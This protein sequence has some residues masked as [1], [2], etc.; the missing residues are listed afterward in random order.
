MH[1]ENIV[2]KTLGIKDHRIVK[3][4]S[5]TENIVVYLEA[6]RK[7][8]LPCGNCGARSR[9]A[10]RVRTERMFL[11]VPLWGI[12]MFLHYRPWRVR[13]PRCGLRR[14]QLH[15]ADG[16]EQITKQLSVTIATWAR[17]LAIDVVARMFGVHWNTV[18][19]AVRKV[20]AYGL[21]HRDLGTILHIG[22]DEISRKK[23]HRYLTQV[24]DLG[25]RRLL[26]SGKDRKEETLR[27]F[28]QIHGE[29][30]RGTAIGVCCDMWAPYIKVIREFLPNAVL[31]FD[32]FHLMKHLLDAV[33]AVRKEE[34]RELR[35]IDPEVL[36]GAKYVFLK[37]PENLTDRQR[38]RMS[39]LEKLNLRINRA[40][41]LKEEFKQ[42][43][44]YRSRAWAEKFLTRWTRRVM[45][46]RLKPLKKFVGLVR[47]HWDGILAWVTLSISNGAVEGMNNN[48]KAISHRSRGFSSA[49]TFSSMLMHCM[50][51]LPM[52]ELSHSFV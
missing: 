43:F 48:A 2:K 47:R 22:V 35:K 14:E 37:N 34:A 5:G 12:A 26:W 4:D 18:Y 21:E 51:D 30:L 38:E 20:V 49:E 46:S 40:Y 6:I 17:I 3:I 11:H 42:L 31:V 27:E 33:D 32:R 44:L 36:K 15:W 16:K 10:D 41:L 9:V 24:Y 45:Y 13:C 7:R 29:Q 25:G 1:L 28:F 23:G 52:P 39:H 19:G 50:G 8:H